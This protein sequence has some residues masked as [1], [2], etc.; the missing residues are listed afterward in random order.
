M[1]PLCTESDLLTLEP[2]IV[3]AAELA[4]FHALNKSAGTL[5]G[6]T[7]TLTSDDFTTAGVLP[8]M[9][10]IVRLADDSAGVNCEVV[11]AAAAVA[12]ISLIRP[13]NG[14]RHS[15]R[16]AGAI[17]VSVLESAGHDRRR[18]R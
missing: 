3:T 11:S 10:A 2:A 1:D 4:D 7:L 12:T 15:A 6:T 16:A 17:T 18:G 8:G 13:P 5:A 14:R 9:V